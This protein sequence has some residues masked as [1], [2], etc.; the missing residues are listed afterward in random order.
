VAKCRIA[1]VRREGYSGWW[2]WTSENSSATHFG[3]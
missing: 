3:E 2:I 1:L